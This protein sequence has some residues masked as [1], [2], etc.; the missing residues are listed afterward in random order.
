MTAVTTSSDPR[1]VTL[2]TPKKRKRAYRPTLLGIAGSLGLLLLW[3]AVSRTEIVPAAYLPPA[4]TVLGTLGGLTLNPAFWSVIGETM[5]SWTLGL[6]IASLLAIPAGLLL[7]RNETAYRMC[8]AVIEALRPIPPVILIPIVVLVLGSTMGMKVFLVTFGVFWILLVQTIYGMRAVEPQLLDMARSFRLNRR[9][10][11]FK[12]RL[13]GALPTLA[14]GLRL[15]A[16]TAL[17]ISIVAELVGGAPGLGREILTAESFANFP[18]MYALILA[19]GIL[20]VL[21]NALLKVITD[22]L[23]FWHPSVRKVVE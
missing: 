20:G 22:R 18:L 9:D 23:L 3:E 1:T 17:V 21:I 15:A 14:A 2:I 4:S 19:A 6:G 13:A 11:F 16:T 5:L 8:S 12:I 10:V 7:A